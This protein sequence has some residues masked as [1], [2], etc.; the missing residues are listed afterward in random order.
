MRNKIFS[1]QWLF[2]LGLTAFTFLSFASVT[3]ADEVNTSRLETV[4][5]VGHKLTELN[6]ENNAGALGNRSV[7]DTPFSVDVISLEDMEIRQVNTLDSLLSR[8]ASVSVDG[9]AYSS[10]GATVRVRGLP[11][12]YTNSFKING[13]SLNNFSGEL[14][15]EA[16]Q[17][18]TLLKGATGFMYGAVAPGGVI[19]YVTKKPT[20][21]L[22]SMDLGYR[23]ESV[24]SGHID[25]ASRFGGAERFGVRVNLVK[26]SGDTYLDNGTIDRNTAAFAF[27]ANL[28]DSLYWTVDLIYNDRRTENSATTMNNRMDPSE[29]LPKAVNGER[30]IG[31]DGAF[32][33]HKNVIGLTRLSWKMNDQWTAHFEYDNAEN[34]TQ[35]VKVLAD[36]TS[37][38]GNVN[39]GLYDQYFDV[40]FSQLQAVIEG[41][42]TTGNIVHQL[43]VGASSQEAK[44]FR[45]DPNRLVTRGYG[46]DNLYQAVS[47]PTYHS[48]LPE[49]LSLS[50]TDEQQSI[51]ISDAISLNAQW[52]VL[53]GIRSTDIEHTPSEY[54]ESFQD[55]YEDSSISPTAALMF[56]PNSQTQYYL[57]YVESFEG[58]TSAVGDTYENANELLPPLESKQYEAGLKMEADGWSLTSALFR[59]ERGAELV[60]SDNYLVQDGMTLYQGFEFGGAAQISDALSFYGEIMLMLDASYEKTNGATEGND[61]A[62]VPDQQ[63]TL[64]FNYDVEALQGLTL[65]LGGKYHGKTTLDAAN[66]WEL[67]AY[68]VLYGGASYKTAL[69]RRDLTVIATIDNL[70]GEDYWAVA[71]AYGGLRIGEPRSIALKF[72]LDL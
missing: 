27:D 9:S 3:S 69:G 1:G 67:P 68:N 56:K 6:A 16:F 19:N 45:N 39:I 55:V 36:L 72:K 13:L 8:E 60:T 57:S 26:E 33:D 65:N 35:W 42:F 44:T 10:F 32:D 21:S 54:F 37:S 14:P 41:E 40:N 23:S 2:S 25:A 71:D 17:Q 66:V 51:F 49:D 43:V 11:L 20:E 29:P 15:Y 4:N 24:F 46:V 34:D 5:V 50:W 48:T 38:D 58:S 47:L 18:V 64:Q 12:D 63:L 53:L 70:L 59:I 61:V 52:E 7:M 22:L 31:V 62:G 30:N 28:T